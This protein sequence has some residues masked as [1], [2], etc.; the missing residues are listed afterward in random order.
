MGS[1]HHHLKCLLL[2]WAVVLYRMAGAQT[3]TG[4]VVGHVVDS[5]QAP[6]AGATITLRSVERGFERHTMTNS[7]GEYAFALVPPGKFTLHVEVSGSAPT[8][9]NV[10]VVVA[11]PVRADLILRVQSLTQEV[12][13]IGESGVSVQTENASLGRTINPHEM[14]ELPGLHRKRDSESAV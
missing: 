1:Q 12:K 10:E 7:Q 14:S 13:V 11:T 3:F 9:V 6:I 8:T 4:A 5:Q 2:F